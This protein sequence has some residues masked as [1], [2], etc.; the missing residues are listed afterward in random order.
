MVDFLLISHPMTLLDPVLPIEVCE[1]VIDQARDNAAS[2]RQ[3]SLTCS[4][5]LP[6]ARCHLFSSIRIRAVEQLQGSGE[7]LDSHPWIIHIIRKVALRIN[8]LVPKHDSRNNDDWD[9]DD[10]DDDDWDDDNSL[11]DDNHDDGRPQY[12][13]LDSVPVHLLSRL[14]NLRSWSI[15]SNDPNGDVAELSLHHLTISCYRRYGVGINDLEVSHVVFWNSI[16][17]FARLISAFSNLQTLSCS[18]IYFLTTEGHNANPGTVN[19]PGTNMLRMPETLRN[20]HV[21]VL[22][23]GSGPS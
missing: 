11:D 21:S 12:R 2:L 17:D 19:N 10:W 1:E 9:D 13:L 7:F 18:S 14:P 16:L 23:P 8:V 15:G 22:L 4:A 3:L 5:F 6:R 20:L